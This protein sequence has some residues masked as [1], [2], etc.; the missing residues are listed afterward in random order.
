MFKKSVEN[1]EENGTKG[2]S[3]SHQSKD[4]TGV[5]SRVRV[6]VSAGVSSNAFLLRG[7]VFVA[8]DVSRIREALM[9]CRNA[10]DVSARFILLLVMNA[11]FIFIRT[12]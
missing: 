1:I 3:I 6:H 10:E 4:E 5:L 8:N 11:R 9:V 12:L 2:S 7:I